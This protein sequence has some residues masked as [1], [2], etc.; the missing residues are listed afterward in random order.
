[1][2][3]NPRGGLNSAIILCVYIVAYVILDRVS[4]V[5][6]LPGVGFTLWN[7]P[8]AASLALIIINGLWFAPVLF[9][10]AVLADVLNGA[11]SIWLVPALTSDAIIA[12]GYTVV[13][14]AL[15]PF[16]RP[17]VGL[18]SVRDVSWFLVI[19][20]LGVLAIAVLDGVALVLLDVVPV[21][22]FA[23]TVR[24][25]WVGDV[26]GVVGL[27][28]AL[29]TAPLAWKRWLELS[30]RT[31]IVDLG[32]FA[33]GLAAAIWIVFGVAPPQEFQ[34]F[35]LLLLP[36]IWIGVRNGLPW[37]AFAILIEQVALVALVTLFDYPESDIIAFQILSLA[38]AVTGLV[39]GAIV[40][41][42]Q[43][44]E[45]KLR[46]QQAELGR[47]TRLVTAG[48]L[49]SAIAHEISQPLA[50][51]ATY[52]HSCRRLPNAGPQGEQLLMETLTKIESEALRAGKIVDRLRD[53]LSK[54]DTQLAPLA[55]EEVAH[56]MAGALVDEAQLHGVEVRI[57]AQCKTSVV[58]DRVQ[59]EQVLVNLIRNGIEAAAE[60]A[61][62]ERLVTVRISQSDNDI[63]VDVED[64]GP[65]VAPEVMGH[66]FEPFMTNKIG[67]MGLGLLLGRQIVESHGGR[68]WCESTSAMGSHFA[69]DL[70]RVQ[71]N[72]D[73]RY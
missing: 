71:T 9:V 68:L 35:Y 11:V 67:G 54:G 48:A 10:A 49:G 58:A 63:R 3:A 14:V 17:Q 18:Q 29:M 56:G 5:Q 69:F 27:F 12:A 21:T 45:I 55:V 1:M 13:A 50:T 64:N 57:E 47:V 19:I 73:V 43:H 40:T 52:A 31:R 33:L 25:F 16:V 34:F 22:R 28:P 62:G 24:H 36:V 66:L 65:G 37:C 39:L 6:A 42:R 15:R 8:P 4:L 30:A 32:S 70:P 7:P 26:T 23:S 53:F 72:V 59:V 41:E 61:S 38:V 51:L 2:A 46:Q 20:S 60:R 44:A